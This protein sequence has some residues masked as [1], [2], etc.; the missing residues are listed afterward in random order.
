MSAMDWFF[1]QLVFL[2]FFLWFH[3]ITFS[4]SS[5]FVTRKASCEGLPYSLIQHAVYL[6]PLH[7]CQAID[8]GIK[9]HYYPVMAVFTKVLWKI[10]L[11][12]I[13]NRLP[14]HGICDVCDGLILWTSGLSLVSWFN[15]LF[16][17]NLRITE[18]LLW[19][20]TL[21]PYSA[22]SIPGSPSSFPSP[23]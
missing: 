10:R 15:L 3:C 18:C 4:F 19:R 6:A 21:F 23:R 20:L 13:L 5:T 7:R 11:V 1:K 17:I 12:N 16:F 2:S 14:K 8:K 9:L 22:H